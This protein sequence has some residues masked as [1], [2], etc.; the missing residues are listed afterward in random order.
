MLRR[1]LPRRSVVVGKRRWIA[2]PRF[3]RLSCR[4]MESKT[5]G[6]LLGRA[7][8]RW[9][10]EKKRAQDGAPMLSLS[11]T[12]SSSSAWPPPLS[13]MGG[14]PRRRRSR[15]RRAFFLMDARR[16]RSDILSSC[17]RY[18]VNK[19]ERGGERVL[20]S[21]VSFRIERAPLSSERA[22]VFETNA[23]TRVQKNFERG[24]SNPLRREKRR[25]AEKRASLSRFTKCSQQQQHH[26]QRLLAASVSEPPGSPPQQ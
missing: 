7:A 5:S 25:G 16:G 20:L 11:S 2:P 19:K 14:G 9:L 15:F 23:G 4:R 22:K 26:H 21:G 10:E 18:R 24:D 6:L 12:L 17:C 8:A 3:F 13:S 1:P